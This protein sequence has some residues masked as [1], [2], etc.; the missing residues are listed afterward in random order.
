MK[1][2]PT[3]NSSHM[4]SAQNSSFYR[5]HAQSSFG[6]ILVQQSASKKYS[7]DASA[8]G[9]THSFSEMPIVAPAA[10][11]SPDSPKTSSEEAA[12]VEGIEAGGRILRESPTSR[13]AL[14]EA[15]FAAV[16]STSTIITRGS[17]DLFRHPMAQATPA[18]SSAPLSRQNQALLRFAQA[19]PD[20]A[21]CRGGTYGAT[22]QLPFHV[23]LSQAASGV[24]ISITA[25][26][27]SDSEKRELEGKSSELAR[28][29]GFAV[30]EVR[31][32]KFGR[33]N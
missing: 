24:R 14:H 21:I 25:N 22:R 4:A 10:I 6:N 16:E 30:S 29:C 13:H 32:G 20:S 23:Q 26:S 9:R 31:V 28:R 18:S 15:T 8:S 3:P 33:R 2:G 17:A 5:E 19:S 27:L 11:D 12:E 1:I 7:Y